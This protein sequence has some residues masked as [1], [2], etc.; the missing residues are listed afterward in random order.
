MLGWRQLRLVTCVIN[1]PR[2]PV[3][4]R[5]SL[6]E[7][8]DGQNT[9]K[10]K[11]ASW[12]SSPLT[13]CVLAGLRAD[14]RPGRVLSL[15]PQSPLVPMA[16]WEALWK[17]CETGWFFFY[18]ANVTS[19][20]YLYVCMYVC[21]IQLQLSAF[22]PHSSTPASPTSLPNFYPHPWFC[23]CVLYSSSYRPLSLLSPPH[24]PLAIVTLFLISMS[25]VIF[26]LLFSFVDYVPVKG[27]I[28]LIVCPE[29]GLRCH[30][31]SIGSKILEL[32]KW[33]T[34]SEL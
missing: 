7:P 29:I 1:L 19:N 23:P 17:N 13:A 9:N 28:I 16:P 18:R 3:P 12:D 33:P 30:P 14:I 24:A 32:E 22:S 34:G 21:I 4:M 27:E 5:K 31:V 15:L 11:N 25:L 8:P 26:C 6:K 10:S 2:E 20:V